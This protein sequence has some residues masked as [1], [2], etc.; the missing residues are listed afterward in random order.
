M[1]KMNKTDEKEKK[2]NDEKND[3]ECCRLEMK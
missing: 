1:N 3:D 2:M